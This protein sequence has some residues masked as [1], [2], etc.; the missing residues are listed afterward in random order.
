MSSCHGS[1][2]ILLRRVL[3]TTLFACG[4]CWTPAVR[5]IPDS[6]SRYDVLPDLAQMHFE[7][8]RSNMG[9]GRL[10]LAR[11]TLERLSREH[12]DNLYV[13]TWLQEVELA[14]ADPAQGETRVASGSNPAASDAGRTA[15]DA[16]QEILRKCYLERAQEHPSAANLVLAARL[17]PDPPAARKLLERAEEF[18]SECAWAHY[19]R[20]FLAARSGNWPDAKAGIARAKDADPGHMPTR[21]LESWML[22]RAGSVPEAI[23][24]FETWL[25]KARG[26]LRLDSRLFLEAKLDLALLYVLDGDSKTSRKLLAEFDQRELEK[27]GSDNPGLDPTD[28]VRAAVLGLIAGR[29]LS[30]LASAEEAQGDIQAALSAAKR[31]EENLPGDLLPVVQ[32]ALLYEAWLKD[33]AAAE[34]AWTRVLAMARCDPRSSADL[35]TLLERLR[36]RVRLERFQERR[37]KDVAA[38]G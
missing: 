3:A 33:A 18:D 21:W 20:A 25:E 7:E 19:A 4:S 30:I 17:E 28:R 35:S 24:S 2:A 10:E 11:V 14:S 29:Q 9:A 8:A 13:G 5:S 32:Q 27:A 22:A 23:T 26:D 34:A 16:P 15:A 37:A 1:S 6:K 12:P 38:R 31:A 36:A